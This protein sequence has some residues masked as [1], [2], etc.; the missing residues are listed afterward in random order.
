MDQVSQIREKTD[1]VSLISEYIPLK[2]AGRNFKANCPFHNEATPSFV[3]SPE[4]QIWHC[5]GC[6]KG[7]DAYTFI[8]EYEN[9]DFPEA[10]RTLAKKAGI[11]LKDNYAK[12]NATSEKERIY[13]LNAQSAKFYNYLLTTHSQ[14]KKAL[15]Y[16]LKDR[17]INK[18]LIDSFSI[19]FSPNSGSSLSEYLIKKKGY[20]KKDLFD[21][22]LSFERGGRVY[23][24]FRGRIMFPLTDHRGNIVGFSGRATELVIDGPKYINTRDTIVYHKGNLFFGFDKARDDIKKEQTAIVVEGEFDMISLYKEGIKN[25]VAIKGTALT[26]PQAVL[27][28]RF[29]P[30]VIL[31]LDQDEAGLEATKRSIPILEKAKLTTKIINL[32]GK[33]PD[34]AINS[35][36]LGFKKALK[37]TQI[38][39]DFIISHFAS[40]YD[41]NTAEG[42]KKIVDEMKDIL[43]VVE[44]EVVREH[45]IKLLSKEIDTSEDSIRKEI[46]KV[47][48]KEEVNE[49]IFN[50]KDKR[51]RREM[52]EEYLVSIIIQSEDPTEY[53]L[54]AKEYLKIYQ[55]EIPSYEKILKF[56]VEYMKG[57]SK[58]DPGRF[59]KALPEEIVKSFDSAF[60]LPIIKVEDEKQLVETEKVLKEMVS[61]FAKERIKEIA[62]DLKDKNKADAAKLKTE[63]NALLDFLS[64]NSL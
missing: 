59:A 24:F 54:K 6:Q 18:G 51:T 58:F 33:D 7:G 20:T 3:V 38:I 15:D 49:P 31:A 26:E 46:E 22:G 27:L 50:K 17:K 23:D 60:L 37:D 9:M 1:I 34:E 30:T 5:F 16:L 44:N 61:L 41:K 14:G 25:V 19:G 35:D 40:I 43:R 8:M 56:A 2:K 32:G 4:R 63:M 12:S 47:K 13:K 39:Y 21:A 11:E 29:A 10:L 45:Y 48:G 28:Y 64:Q 57:N 42:K 36:P 55:F 53:L 62:G 52:L